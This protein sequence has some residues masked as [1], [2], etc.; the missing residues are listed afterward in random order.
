MFLQGAFGKGALTVFGLT[1]YTLLGLGVV[2]LT[3]S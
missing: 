3:F 1:T 2:S